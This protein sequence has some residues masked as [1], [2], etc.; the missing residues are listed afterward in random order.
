MRETPQV[1]H[2]YDDFHRV[3]RHTMEITALV[4]NP[5]MC[6]IVRDGLF[7]IQSSILISCIRNK[8]DNLNSKLRRPTMIT[9]SRWTGGH[10]F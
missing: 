8:N 9:R 4:K 3:S 7:T 2:F 10:S 5:S 1:F 6:T